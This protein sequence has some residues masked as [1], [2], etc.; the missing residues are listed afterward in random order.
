[1]SIVY[2]DITCKAGL[3]ISS[4][5]PLMQGHL[6][7]LALDP[8][9]AITQVGLKP[10]NLFL[11][12]TRKKDSPSSS[13]SDTSLSMGPAIHDA[14]TYTWLGSTSMSPPTTPSSCMWMDWRLAHTLG[15]GNNPSH[16]PKGVNACAF[17]KNSLPPD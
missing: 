5:C 3:E 12:L 11:H 16:Q 4:L 8:R 17:L 15:A 1:M 6:F 7:V 14:K 10:C 9:L 13:S 2:L